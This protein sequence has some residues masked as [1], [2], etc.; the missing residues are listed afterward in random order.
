MKKPKGMA[1]ASG[2]VIAQEFQEWRKSMKRDGY[3]VAQINAAVRSE[4]GCSRRK[5]PRYTIVN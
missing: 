3:T 1:D 5:G 2:V 4:T